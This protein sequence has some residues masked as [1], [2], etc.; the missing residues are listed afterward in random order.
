MTGTAVGVAIGAVLLLGSA[1]SAL[2]YRAWRNLP[3]EP[4]TICHLCPH[5]HGH[6]GDEDLADHMEA[7]H[8][9]A[10]LLWVDDDEDAEDAAA[11]MIHR[12][13]ER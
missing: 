9:D 11:A 3:P 6:L 5:G 12:S 1:A 13:G 8:P 4:G 10:A 7:F 2:A